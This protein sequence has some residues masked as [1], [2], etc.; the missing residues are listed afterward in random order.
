MCPKDITENTHHHGVFNLAREKGSVPI[1]L[2]AQEVAVERKENLATFC[3]FFFIVLLFICAYKAWVI[4]PPC[5]HLL[6]Y[7][8]S[9]HLLNAAGTQERGLDRRGNHK[10]KQ[11]ITRLSWRNGSGCTGMEQKQGAWL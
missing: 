7:H 1:E 4:S 6:P 3:F 8:P 10:Q 5:P 2:G 11:K 9:S